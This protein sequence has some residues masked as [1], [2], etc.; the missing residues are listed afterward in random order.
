MFLSKLIARYKF[1]M[2]IA[3]RLS[4]PSNYKIQRILYFKLYYGREYQQKKKSLNKINILLKAQ[5]ISKI[6]HYFFNQ[7]FK[8]RVIEN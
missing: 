4:R 2:K 8:F 1:K 7:F 6:R 3:Q 5:K